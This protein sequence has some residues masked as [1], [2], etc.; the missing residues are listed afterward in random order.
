MQTLCEKRGL[1]QFSHI[2]RDGD[3]IESWDLLILRFDLEVFF[4]GTAINN[5]TKCRLTMAF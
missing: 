3:F 1:P 2:D 4:L 5:V